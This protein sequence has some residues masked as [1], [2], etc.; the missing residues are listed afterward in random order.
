MNGGYISTNYFNSLFSAP[1]KTVK[2]GKI[3]SISDTAIFAYAVSTNSDSNTVFLTSANV[4]NT[5]TG[6]TALEPSAKPY[7]NK[8]FAVFRKGGDGAILLPKQV[9]NTNLIGTYAPILR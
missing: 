5:P 6:G 3:P 7:G 9:G 8:G 1:G 2:S 4:T